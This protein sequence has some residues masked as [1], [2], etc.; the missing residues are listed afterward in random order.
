MHANQV[1]CLAKPS[2]V[3]PVEGAPLVFSTAL[4]HDFAIG[5]QTENGSSIE[6]PAI[7]DAARGGFVID[8]H[9][10]ENSQLASRISGKLHGFW[11]YQSFAGPNF[12]LRSAHATKWS[13][14]AGIRMHSSL[15]ARIRCIYS[16]T[17]LPVSRTSS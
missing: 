7:A 5:V 10:L 6:L 2:L 16:P 12:D 1:F 11:G 13:V 9:A 3:L 4:A 15:A 17:A 14:V 8:T